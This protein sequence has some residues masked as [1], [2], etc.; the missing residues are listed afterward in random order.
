MKRLIVISIILICS[1]SA[2]SA[3]AEGG[4]VRGDS[5]NGEVIQ[6]LCG[7]NDDCS[8]DPYWWL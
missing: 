2:V 6:N 3:F 5:G 7:P 1:T 8:G 4:K